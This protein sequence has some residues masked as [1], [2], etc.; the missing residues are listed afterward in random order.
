LSTFGNGRERTGFI[1][2]MDR[3]LQDR[4]RRSAQAIAEL[5]EQLSRSTAARAFAHGMNPVH[6]TALRYFAQANES[7]R[8]IG[9]FAK[10]NRTTPS[11]ASQ[12]VSALETKGLL[13]KK[14]GA[15]SRRRVIQLTARGRRLLERDPI[16]DL[17]RAILS[18]SQ[19]EMFPLADVMGKIIQAVERAAADGRDESVN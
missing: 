1:S 16:N 11:S 19:D 4:R 8:T 5:I 2:I 18:L 3:T 10:F 14:A 7:A 17:A 12:T 6:W 9:A 15:D 13:I